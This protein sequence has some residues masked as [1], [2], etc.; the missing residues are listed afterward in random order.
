MST[1]LS[2]V[3]PRFQLG[4][5]DGTFALVGLAVFLVSFVVWSAH[6][7][8]VEKTDFSVTYVGAKLIH[9][10]KARDLYDFHKQQEVRDSLFRKPS[11]LFFEHPPFEA[12]ILSPLAG[13]PYR[14]AYLMWGIFNAALL[15]CSI[16]FLRPFLLWP[17][18][19]LAYTFLWALFAPLIVTLYQ[20]QSSL[21]LFAIY[22]LTFWLLK[23]RRDF[24]AGLALGI[25]LFKFQFVI[26][27]ALILFLLKRWRVSAGF[28]VSS[29]FLGVLSTIAVG[30]RGLYDYAR[31]IF[32][33][34]SNPQ[35]ESY[36]SAV[37]MPTLHGL[38]YAVLG[39][40][41]SH[42]ALSGVVVLVSL[43]LLAWVTWSWRLS[44]DT[45]FDVM[46]AAALTA[47][48][49]S[50]SHMF[51]HD[52]SPLILAMFL[53]GTKLSR[54]SVTQ[55]ARIRLMTWIVL[56]ILWTFPLYFVLVAFHRLYLMCLVLLLLIYCSVRIANILRTSNTGTIEVLPAS[57]E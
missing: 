42:A 36:G 25:G 32:T 39:Q 12:L 18:E 4:F 11:P 14:T 35:N 49:V 55:E 45:N 38:I 3:S 30:W 57:N 50:G 34:A 27:F 8:N 7:P 56:G 17:K 52:F 19:H 5:N 22:A 2:V 44:D 15:W 21:V 40:N 31:F 29:L 26:P 13:L 20:G 41:I 47:A 46:F 37:D 51:T 9:D 33:I 10:G 16:I 53:L 48:L 1:D 23:S 6:S 54:F 43:V 28:V 24:L